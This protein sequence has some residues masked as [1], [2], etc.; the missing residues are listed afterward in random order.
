MQNGV[1]HYLKQGL[2]D[3]SPLHIYLE[4]SKLFIRL[5]YMTQ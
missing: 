2:Y 3:F 1:R 5:Q 4:V